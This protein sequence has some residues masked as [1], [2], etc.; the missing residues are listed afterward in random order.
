MP[1]VYVHLELYNRFFWMSITKF[2]KI[3]IGGESMRVRL[4]YVAIA[5]KLPKVTSSSNVT[6]TFYQRLATEEKKI[7]KL[8]QIAYSNIVDLKKILEYNVENNIH[9]YRIT[10][11]LIPLATHPDVNW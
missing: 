6:Y 5:L 10:S 9:F 11:A 1:N 8:K 2:S 3:K 7:N 4:G